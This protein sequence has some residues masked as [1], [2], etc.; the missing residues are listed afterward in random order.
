MIREDGLFAWNTLEIVLIILA[1]VLALPLLFYAVHR[2]LDYFCVRHARKFCRRKGLK[3]RRSRS[4]PAFDNS[5]V[6]T[7]LTLVE[8]DCFDAQ[9]QRRLVRLVVWPFGIRN[10]VIDDEYPESYDVEWPPS[11][12]RT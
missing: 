10:V 12:I 3:V 1:G 4:Q 11:G 6:K 9:K 8:L 2:G 7:E 5:G